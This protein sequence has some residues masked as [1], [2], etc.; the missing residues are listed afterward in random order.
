VGT[1]VVSG[2]TA[3]RLEGAVLEPKG[4]LAIKGKTAPVRAFELV[5]LPQ[6]RHADGEPE[7]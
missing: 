1:I 5:G 4:E 7:A 3:E 6:E 2:A